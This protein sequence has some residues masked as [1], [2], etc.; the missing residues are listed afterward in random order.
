[1]SAKTKGYLVTGSIAFVVALGAIFVANNVKQI[2]KVVE[3]KN[4]GWF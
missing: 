2:E 1:M 3:K 4:T